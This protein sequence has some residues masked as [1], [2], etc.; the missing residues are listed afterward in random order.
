MALVGTAWAGVDSTNQTA[1]QLRLDVELVDGSRII[2]VPDIASMPV[3]TAYAKMDIPLAQISTIAIQPGQ[4]NVTVRLAN[5]DSLTGTL[6]RPDLPIDTIMGPLQVPVSIITKISISNRGNKPLSMGDGPIAFCGFNW[7][8][9]RTGFEVRGDKVVTLPRAAD[10]FN[11]GHGGNGR[12]GMLYTNIG[13]PDWK[14]YRAEFTFCI[15]P[16]D[17]AFNRYGIGPSDRA[18]YIRFHVTDA[19]QSWNQKGL[20]SYSLFIGQKGSWGL[21]RGVNGRTPNAVGYTDWVADGKESLASGEG[22]VPDPVKGNRYIIEIK[23]QRI[24]IYVDGDLLADVEDPEMHREYDGVHLGYGGIGIEW[25][26]ENMGWIS[27]F[28]VNGI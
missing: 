4:T 8:G 3:Q 13:N 19:R 16:A 20:S 5:G 21:G 1:A 22:F 14:D 7:V 26:W 28:S 11:Y 12:G 2:G 24:R 18:G 9:W 15:Q 6:V 27:D 25:L 17:P 23:G 10:G